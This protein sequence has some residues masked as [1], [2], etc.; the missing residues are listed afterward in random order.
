MDLRN[1]EKMTSKADWIT[2][3]VHY[4]VGM[5][6][7]V[8]VAFVII[9]ELQLWYESSFLLPILIGSVAFC[10]GVSSIYGDRF[11]RDFLGRVTLPKRP[12]TSSVSR[13]ISMSSVVGGFVLLSTMVV[14]YLYLSG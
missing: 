12:E 5:V 11:W 9:D 6:L 13:V 4:L 7:G 8:V 2:W 10:G 1:N 14:K 3:S